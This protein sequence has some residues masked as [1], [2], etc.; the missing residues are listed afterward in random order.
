MCILL[1]VVDIS[2]GG[3]YID[4]KE[5]NTQRAW[6]QYAQMDKQKK[7]K[8]LKKHHEA[9]QQKKGLLVKTRESA[10]SQLH[11]TTVITSAL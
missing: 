4:V 1:G 2:N 6:E 9:Y 3:E 5:R 10:L 11:S 7:D 8:L